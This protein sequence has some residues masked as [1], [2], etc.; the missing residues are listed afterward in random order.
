MD[1][2]TYL[3]DDNENPFKTLNK[4]LIH[5]MTT[6]NRDNQFIGRN[7]LAKIKEFQDYCKLQDKNITNNVEKYKNDISKFKVEATRLNNTNTLSRLENRKLAVK[8][9][10]IERVTSKYSFLSVF[11]DSIVSTL[12]IDVNHIT[13]KNE[14]SDEFVNNLLNQYVANGEIDSVRQI[15]E[16]ER[17]VK[18]RRPTDFQTGSKMKSIEHKKKSKSRMKK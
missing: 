8:I 10:N 3:H 12:E 4:E 5:Y 13:M 17:N 9:Q 7:V 6:V 1:Y 16:R 15:S 18:P 2:R 14:D 11:L